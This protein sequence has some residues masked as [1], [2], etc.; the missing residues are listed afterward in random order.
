M[1]NEPPPK[2]PFELLGGE[3]TIQAIVDR[4]YDLM[5]CDP[6]YAELR[7]MH[8]PDLSKMRKSLAGFLSAWAGGPQD[9]FE[10]NPG[11]CMMSL[12][13]AYAIT[14]GVAAQWAEAMQRATSDAAP[15][16]PAIARRM[17]EILAEMAKNM[18]R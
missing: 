12:H 5:D 7:A 6:A 13:R 8:A 16:D 9:W 14:P 17:G 2:S 3:Q 11:K 10:Q 18:G 4:F 15:A 1:V